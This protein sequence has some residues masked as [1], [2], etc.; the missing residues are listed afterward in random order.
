MQ[1]A[2]GTFNDNENLV[3]G[4]VGARLALGY[5]LPEALLEVVHVIVLEDADRR[6]RVANTHDD[7]RVV[8]GIGDDERSLH[9]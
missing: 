4:A 6:G 1:K 5:G 8:E 7:R 3:P 9:C 2:V